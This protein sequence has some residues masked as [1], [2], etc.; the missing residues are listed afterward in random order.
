MRFTAQEEYGLRCILHLARHAESDSGASR[1]TADEASVRVGDVAATEGVSEPYVSR[2]FRLLGKSGLVESVRGRHGGFR[3]TRNP[4]EISVSETLYALDGAL[5]DGGT[6]ER[7]SGNKEEC[8]HSSDCS[9]RSL[10]SGVQS[11]LDDVLSQI[12]LADLALR[13]STASGEST[14][15]Q[16]VGRHVLALRPGADA[17]GTVDAAIDHPVPPA[18]HSFVGAELP[19]LDAGRLGGGRADAPKTR[20]EADKES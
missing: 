20:Y 12:S 16:S 10:W 5:Y 19:R 17:A 11:L 14:A 1:S 15:R 2:L 13:G 3:L 9:I 7:Y 6:C 8:V 18:R 4:S